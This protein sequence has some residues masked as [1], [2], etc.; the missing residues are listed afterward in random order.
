MHCPKHS[1]KYGHEAEKYQKDHTIISTNLKHTH[2]PK[3]R[4]KQNEHTRKCF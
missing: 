1:Y 3:P 4:D 2:I